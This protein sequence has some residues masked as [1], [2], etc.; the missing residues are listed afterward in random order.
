MEKPHSFEFPKP[1]EKRSQK[2]I[3][4]A[5]RE[6]DENKGEPLLPELPKLSV[7]KEPPI[8]KTKKQVMA[9]TVPPGKKYF[10]IGEVADL[11]QVE[12]YVLR[13]WES[14]FSAIKPMKSGSGHR[15][16]S[17]RDV[18]ILEQVRNLLYEEKFSIDG[19][20]KRLKELK[21]QRKSQPE[22]SQAKQHHEL[23]KSLA[24]QAKELIHIARGASGVF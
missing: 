5:L 15:V 1:S 8:P 23:L 2:F 24:K 4:D 9:L 6:T 20:K 13:Y 7:P 12:P 18:E 22:I 10:R 3:L 21:T 19:A 16:Y 11:L 14:E 17:R